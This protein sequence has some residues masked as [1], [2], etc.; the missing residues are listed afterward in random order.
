MSKIN[1]FL[2]DVNL[3]HPEVI[4]KVTF[5][6]H[7]KFCKVLLVGHTVMLS[8]EMPSEF[9]FFFFWK[10]CFDNGYFKRV[11]RPIFW[12][13]Y[14]TSKFYRGSDWTWFSL[15]FP[16]GQKS[17]STKRNIE[18][19]FKTD[20]FLLKDLGSLGSI[21]YSCDVTVQELTKGYYS[22]I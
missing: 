2:D 3:E 15:I 9:F 7:F 22:M 20:H 6:F 16:Y 13:Q 11:Y 17:M 19:W 8:W 18:R 10:F 12:F 1:I 14:P 5:R 4:K 21:W